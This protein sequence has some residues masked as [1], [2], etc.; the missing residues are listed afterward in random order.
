[1]LFK[2][3]KKEKEIYQIVFCDDKDITTEIGREKKDYPTYEA[4]KTT[5]FSKVNGWGNAIKEIDG[6]MAKVDGDIWLIIQK[7]SKNS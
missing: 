1:M 3:K 5:I 6:D 4:A 7:L 2:R